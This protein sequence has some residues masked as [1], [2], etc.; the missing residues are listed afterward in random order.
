MTKR[1]KKENREN[2]YDHLNA[3]DCRAWKIACTL[4]SVYVS[5]TQKLLD[6]HEKTCSQKTWVFSDTFQQLISLKKYFL[7]LL[8]PSCLFIEVERISIKFFIRFINMRIVILVPSALPFAPPYADLREEKFSLAQVSISKS[9]QE[10][11]GDEYGAF[12]Y[13][14]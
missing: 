11:A 14:G 6:V 4:V 12:C 5:C 1:K 3:F 7:S 2:Q 10:C 8:F 13:I 9:E